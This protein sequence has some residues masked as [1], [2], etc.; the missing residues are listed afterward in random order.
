MKLQ[1][2]F[3]YKYGDK[4]RYKYLIT[5]PEEIIDE[6]GWESGSDLATRIIDGKNLLVE[7]VSK[8]TNLPKKISEPKISYEEFRD[9]IKNV[10]EYSDKG[11]TWT[12]LR[13]RLKLDQVVPNNKWVR[14][15]EKDI[16]LMRF[17]EMRGIVWRIRHV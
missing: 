13:N 2:A 16:G 10:L 14:Q 1:R 8:P 15:M 17:K 11:M 4:S 3:A 5:I 9:K 6:L 12:E 7:F